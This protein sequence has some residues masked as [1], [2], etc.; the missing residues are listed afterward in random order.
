MEYKV[1]SPVQL[2]AAVYPTEAENRSVA[3]SVDDES[4]VS[5]SETGMVTARTDGQWIK[6]L[7]S[8]NLYGAAGEK[9]ALVPVTTTDGGKQAQCKI[10]VSF[11]TTNNTTSSSSGSILTQYPMELAVRFL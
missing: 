1:T 10:T 8:A 7:E 11:K 9:T 4:V 2:N 5:I 6:D 3:W